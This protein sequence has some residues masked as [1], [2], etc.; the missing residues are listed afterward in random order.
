MARA[1]GPGWPSPRRP[2]GPAGA[3]PRRVLNQQAIVDA[4]LEIVDEEGL[5]ALSMRRVAQRLG[6]GPASLYAHI[7]GKEELLELLLNQVYGELALPGAPD[8]ARWREQAKALLTASRDN[9]AGHGDLARAA[10]RGGSV[11]LPNALRVTEAMLG[12][13]RAGG[14][15]RQ[16][17]AYAMDLLALYTVA[18]AVERALG[19]RGSADGGPSPATAVNAEGDET[20]EEYRERVRDYYASLP[21]E[22]YPILRTM[23]DP[24][25]RNVGDERFQFGL[26]VILGGLASRAAVRGRRDGD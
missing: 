6:T 24:M 18:D 12:I 8:P 15:E 7:S 9:L 5:D 3:P 1:S 2:K 17:A 4:A 26:D 10:L 23:A 14:V 20:N 11:T 21:A 19:L 13:L 22:R 16:E 25:V